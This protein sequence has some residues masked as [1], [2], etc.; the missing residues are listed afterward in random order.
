MNNEVMWSSKSDEWSTPIDFFNEIDKEFHFNLDPC[1]TDENHKCLNYFTKE[2][3]GLS[4]SWGG[5]MF[6]LIHRIQSAKS[7]C[8]KLSTRQGKT[9]HSSFFCFRPEPTQSIFTTIYSTG[10]RSVSFVVDLNSEIRKAP[11]R[12]RQCSL[13]SGVRNVNRITKELFLTTCEGVRN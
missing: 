11:R 8:Q 12:F 13:S 10:A 5:I 2:D 3:D 9:R 6:L 4:K 1:S 7:G